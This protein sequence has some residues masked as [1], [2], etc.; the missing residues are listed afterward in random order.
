MPT[1]SSD[2]GGAAPGERVRTPSRSMELER[3]RRGTTGPRGAGLGVPPAVVAPAV[4]GTG[5]PLKLNTREAVAGADT[6]WED[7]DNALDRGHTHFQQTPRTHTCTRMH[8]NAHE[9]THPAN[10]YSQSHTSHTRR[11]VSDD[12]HLTNCNSGKQTSSA[13]GDNSPLTAASCPATDSS[14]TATA[15]GRSWAAA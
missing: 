1:S 15:H 9:Y 5:W 13:Q 4:P 10:T 3:C 6:W 12:K 8:T 11:S 2:G 7:D 14:P